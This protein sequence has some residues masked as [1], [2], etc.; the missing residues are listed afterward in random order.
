M[1]TS[2]CSFVCSHK[3]K[4]AQPNFTIFWH[5]VRGYVARTYSDGVAIC[6]VLSIMWM[7]SC[8]DAIGPTGRNQARLYVWEKFAGLRYQFD[9]TQLKC[10]VE[11]LTMQH[12][13]W[14]EVCYLRL[15]CFTCCRFFVRR[16]RR[17]RFVLSR[18]LSRASV[19][20]CFFLFMLVW[21]NFLP[22]MISQKLS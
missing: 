14:D 16:F 1:S 4:I 15:T 12:R 22:T 3:S 8:F 19:S 2:I 13:E 9:I 18:K 7:T 5:S 20:F 6:Y 17:R 10:L 21:H 11:F